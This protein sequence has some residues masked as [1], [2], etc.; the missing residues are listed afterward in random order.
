MWHTDRPIPQ[1]RLASSLADLAL[2]L[3]PDLFFR[4]ISA[5]WTTIAREWLQIDALRLDKYLL[6]VRRYVHTGFLYLSQHAWDAVLCRKYLEVMG[7]IPLS[8]SQTKVSDGLRYHV[9]D[10]WVDEL[11]L[12]DGEHDDGQE[13]CPVEELMTVIQRLQKEAKTKKVREMAGECLADKRLEHWTHRAATEENEVENSQDD[14][15]WAGLG[16]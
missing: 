8:P 15:E 3:S 16:D 5:F 4:F 12:V 7:S 2:S 9:L 6:L 11:D 14:T 10:I 13:A 1:Q